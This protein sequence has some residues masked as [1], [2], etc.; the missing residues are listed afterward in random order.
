MGT[1]KPLPVTETRPSL[2][3]Q[4]FDLRL[5]QNIRVISARVTD[6]AKEGMAAHCTFEIE[7]LP[8]FCNRMDN[9]HGGCV[10]LLADMATTMCTAPVSKEDFWRFGGMTCIL[11]P[12]QMVSNG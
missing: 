1:F 3:C 11:I 7:V 5:M 12:V 8:Q 2:T 10:A 4:K 6:I 9:M